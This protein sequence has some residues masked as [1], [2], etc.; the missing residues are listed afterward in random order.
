MNNSGISPSSGPPFVITPSPVQTP[1]GSLAFFRKDFANKAITTFFVVLIIIQIVNIRHALP[2]LWLVLASAT[3][4]LFFN[5]L[6]RLSKSWARLPVVVFRRKVFQ[7]ALLIRVV[8]TIFMYFLYTIMTGVPFEFYAGDSH[9]Y[10]GEGYAL[11]DY[12]LDG[13]LDF[14]N[15][16]SYLDISDMGYPIFL[17]FIYIICFKSILLARICNCVISAWTCLIIYDL[18]KRNF[19]EQVARIAGI[20]TMLMPN[21]IYYCGLTLKETVMVFL[22]VTTVKF[23]DKLLHLKRLKSRDF[24]LLIAA[25]ASLFF[26]RT[27][28]ALA[29]MM[30][31]GTTIVIIG[32]ARFQYGATNFPGFLDFNRHYRYFLY[33]IG[34]RYK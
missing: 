13:N 28:L 31:I 8:V 34:S 29:I 20:M 23:A 24:L 15:K 14:F 7:Q 4:L 6:S 2:I 33:V 22:A 25:G 26:F 10:N 27:V 18:T 11:S 12:I 17:G 5:S 19:N 32:R 1:T 30:A 3:V 9:F 16:L 21:F